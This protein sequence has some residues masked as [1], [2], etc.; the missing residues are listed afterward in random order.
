MGDAA[1]WAAD[2]ALLCETKTLSVVKEVGKRYSLSF[3]D[4][5]FFRAR[6]MVL[7]HLAICEKTCKSSHDQG[8]VAMTPTSASLDAGAEQADAVQG[9]RLSY[10]QA[11]EGRRA[12]RSGLT[13]IGKPPMPRERTL[14]SLLKPSPPPPAAVQEGGA[15]VPGKKSG[16]A[17]TSQRCAPPQPS[18]SPATAAG[19]GSPVSWRSSPLFEK[20]ELV[21]AAAAKLAPKAGSSKLPVTASALA[22]MLAGSE[23]STSA[24]E[25]AALTAQLAQQSSEICRLK[26]QQQTSQ[27]TIL[28]LTQ[29]MHKLEE[30]WGR[31][32]GE[33]AR[34]RELE[35][36]V[37]N[38]Y[39]RQQQMVERQQ[40]AECQHAVVLRT[41][42]TLGASGTHLA[43]AAGELLGLLLGLRVTV[44]R[45]EELSG[46]GSQNSSST[47]GSGMQPRQAYKLVLTS[48]EAR[49]AVL[50]VK[51]CKLRGTP[52][53]LDVCLTAVQQAAKA[54]LLP[55]SKA[56]RTSGRRVQWRYHRLFIDGM[57]HQVGTPL[58][59]PRAQKQGRPAWAGSPANRQAVGPVP[60]PARGQAPC[61][62]AS[63]PSSLAAG[64]AFEISNCT[65]EPLEEGEWQPAL[66]RS[67]KRRKAKQPLRST[68]GPKGARSPPKATSR[69]APHGGSGNRGKSAG[70]GR[71][72]ENNT[73]ASGGKAA[74]QPG[75]ANLGGVRSGQQGQ[76]RRS[77][78]SPPPPPSRA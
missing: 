44:L 57:E 29:R 36:Q 64:P 42:T 39:S 17:V 76:L 58:P 69:P 46:S 38:V 74:K 20:G 40:R 45:V 15:Q 13:P 41:P 21:P 5:S 72:K 18:P 67:Q 30:V 31:T 68:S 6:K 24:A 1:Q 60:P 62:A 70:R 77:T 61:S 28:S 73:P 9:R 65:A 37:G 34:V 78:A 12:G 11:V 47:P 3:G 10:S 16:Q 43:T 54:K 35:V 32:Q 33:A 7:E 55:I 56:A 26:Q 25:H 48:S 2:R 51:A 22:N 53:S 71:G 8:S 4:E 50:R 49:D 75:R 63:S 66:S 27:A 52:H 19:V 59:Q 23:G 14:L